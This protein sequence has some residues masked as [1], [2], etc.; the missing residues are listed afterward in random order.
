MSTTDKVMEALSEKTLRT[1]R[2]SQER[3]ETTRVRQWRPAD[4]LPEPTRQDGWE[5]K[6]IRKSI[7]GVGDPTNMSKSLREGWETCRLEDH[8]EMMLA[9]DGE[10]KNSG[11]IEVG[12]LI[13]CKMP[14]EMF[15]QR[16]RYYEDQANSQ[17][18]SVDAQVEQTNDP[19]MPL[20]KER[21]SK[22]SFGNGR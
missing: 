10:S 1:P 18:D 20:F 14:Q 3:A 22:V 21:Q 11:L 12:G 6:W 7:L 15:N 8:P 4:L 13:L 2:A 17:M 5:Y 19:R 16:Q 9:V